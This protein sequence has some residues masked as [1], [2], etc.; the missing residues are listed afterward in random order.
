MLW[1]SLALEVS[2]RRC[3]EVERVLGGVEAMA[4]EDEVDGTPLPNGR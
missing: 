1:I 2:T 3:S 4:G